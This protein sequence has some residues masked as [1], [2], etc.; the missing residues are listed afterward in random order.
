[1]KKSIR[2]L[3]I[4]AAIFA[5]NY[6]ASAATGDIIAACLVLEAGGE[7]EIGMQAVL[8]VL[9]NRS[10]ASGR[11]IWREAIK[12]WQFSCFNGR[13]IEDSIFLAKLSPSWIVAKVLVDNKNNLPDV[14]GGATH[15]YAPKRCAKP[16][17]AVH[18]IKTIGNHKFY[19]EAPYL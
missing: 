16:S 14:T 13:S 8:N 18:Y 2:I 6:E 4:L 19:R 9:Q 10:K 7:G 3:L 12:P 1:M 5:Y 11:P 15:Y 17:W